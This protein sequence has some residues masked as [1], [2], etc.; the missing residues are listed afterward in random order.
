M[1][2]CALNASF[3]SPIDIIFN[4]VLTPVSDDCQSH[5]SPHAASFRKS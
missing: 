1:T 3:R 2:P 4:S 5:T